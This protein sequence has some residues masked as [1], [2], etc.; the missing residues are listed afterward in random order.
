MVNILSE[1]IWFSDQNSDVIPL[2]Q[3]IVTSPLKVQVGF[4][5]VYIS[6]NFYSDTSL[7]RITSKMKMKITLNRKTQQF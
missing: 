7:K 5:C 4:V 3:E 6:D 1:V 2:N